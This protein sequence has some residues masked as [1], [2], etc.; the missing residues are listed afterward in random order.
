MGALPNGLDRADGLTPLPLAMGFDGSIILGGATGTPTP[1]AAVS[2]SSYD[3]TTVTIDELPESPEF[4]R[5][6]QATVTHRFT[7]PWTEALNRMNWY[8]RGRLL[9]DTY[10]NIYFLL[11]AKLQ[12]KKPHVGEVT[13]VMEAKTFDTPPD[14]F[15]CVPV[16]LGLNIIK[17]PRYFYAFLGTGYDPSTEQLNQHVIRLLQDYFDN[18]NYAFRTALSAMLANSLITEGT[19]STVY[20]TSFIT[21]AGLYNGTSKIRGTN[22]A[23]R[24]AQE[25]IM[26]YWRGEEQPMVVGWKVSW[27]QYYFRPQ[28][29]SAGGVIENPMT[30]ATPQLPEYFTSPTF[31]PT[32]SPTIFD[33]MAYEN[34]QCYSS[35]G[36][37][38]GDVSISWLRQADEIEYQRTW[39]KIKRSWLGAPVGH[40]DTELYSRGNRPATGTDYMTY[41]DPLA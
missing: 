28:C 32:E 17:H 7:L 22:L 35:T 4:E 40:W 20:P 23:K 39:F 2:T 9:Y 41:S 14:E 11:S 34:P 31:P 21:G 12:H 15:E 24:A 8:Y 27:F 33:W 5:A 13:L 18:T 29:L 3:G 16:N 36:A 38:Y 37:L 19:T 25:I 26:K 1:A 6:E 10:G 30:E